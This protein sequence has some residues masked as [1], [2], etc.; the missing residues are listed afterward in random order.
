[1]I[2]EFVT[3][4][5]KPEITA[6][7]QQETMGA[8]GRLLAHHDGLLG[9]DVYVDDEGHWIDHVRWATLEAAQASA[10]ALQEHADAAPLLARFDLAA[11]RLAHYRHVALD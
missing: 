1:M 6:D 2:H 7:Q 5:F 8:L 9:R 3:F 11:T 10:A 4:R